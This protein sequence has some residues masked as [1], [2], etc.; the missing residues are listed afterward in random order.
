MEVL[1]RLIQ[2]K[3]WTMISQNG[4]ADRASETYPWK[5]LT[6]QKYRYRSFHSGRGKI[7]SLWTVHVFFMK[8]LCIMITK[9]PHLIVSLT[10][11]EYR[12]NLNL[13]LNLIKASLTLLENSKKFLWKWHYFEIW[14]NW[15]WLRRLRFL[16]CEQ[17][18]ITFW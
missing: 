6:L 5:I 9:P 18:S 10:S 13:N 2:S 14:L 12:I 16:R 7:L 11:C 1:K 4:R 17:M 8:F 15:R 3:K